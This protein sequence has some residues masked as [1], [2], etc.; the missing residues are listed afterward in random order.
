[1]NKELL[2]ALQQVRDNMPSVNKNAKGYNYKYADLPHL[3]ESIEKVISDAGF[4][5]INYGDGQNVVTVAAHE[6]GQLESKIPLPLN[7]VVQDKDKREEG[8]DPQDLGASI[9]YYRRYNL[10]M[11]FNVMIEDNDAA[12]KPAPAK[13][14]DPIEAEWQAKIRFCTEVEELKKVWESVPDIYKKVLVGVKDT[15]KALI[16][17]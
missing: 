1:M 17:K 2:K 9:T 13:K 15:Q 5:V 8:L 14:F 6:A 7:R 4:T 3:W 10:L 16:T 11:I 12:K